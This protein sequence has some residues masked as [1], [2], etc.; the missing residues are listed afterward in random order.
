[1]TAPRLRLLWSSNG[2]FVPSG[3]G[4]QSKAILPRLA[5]L[6]EFGG[7]PGS[8]EGR[9]NIA[10]FAWYGVQGSKQNVDGFD[11]YPAG[12]DPYGNDVIG[13]YTRHFSANLTISLID[14]WVCRDVAKNIYPSLWCPYLPI[15]HEP[16]PQRVLDSMQG[17]HLPITYSKW[18]HDMLTKAGVKNAYVVHGVEPS[19]FRVIPR[20][21]ALAFKRAVTGVDNA[22]L[23]IMVAANKGF[24][25]RKWFQGQLRAW[26]EFA[27]DKPNAYLYIHTEP[28]QIYGGVD[29]GWLLGHLGIADRVRFPDRLEN[30]LGLPQEYLALVYNA[31]DVLLSCS[32]SEGFGIPIVEAQAA[33]TPV[34][35]TDFS[36]MPELVRWGHTVKVADYVLTP[37]NAYQAWPDVVDMTDKLQRLYEAWDACGGDWPLEKRIATQDAIHAEYSWDT[38]V[39]D[40]WAPLMAKLADEAPPLDARFQAQGVSLPQAHVD[41]AQSFVNELNGEMAKANKPKRRVAPLVKAAQP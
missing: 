28:T 35:V 21:N 38:I 39:R 30:F 8:P 40:Q 23:S 4:I 1:M 36:A 6:P 18:G 19:I 15:D 3:Y 37:M 9:K 5:E 17:A 27:K 29:F 33:G 34:V 11:V 25:D 14:V 20:E 13:P 12:N 24:P 41:D 32:M 2:F 16:I 31:A 26:A 7:V 22:H 10:Q